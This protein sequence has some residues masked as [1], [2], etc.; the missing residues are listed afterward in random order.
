MLGR[1]LVGILDLGQKTINNIIDKVAKVPSVV[2]A[3]GKITTKI[4]DTISDYVKDRFEDS[5][6]ELVGNVTEKLREKLGSPRSLPEA[7]TRNPTGGNEAS[8]YVANDPN[9]GTGRSIVAP[10]APTRGRPAFEPS[11][12][13]LKP[14]ESAKVK[15]VRQYG[16]TGVVAGVVS[17]AAE[18]SSAESPEDIEV[19]RPAYVFLDGETGPH[20]ITVR[21]KAKSTSTSQK[22]FYYRPTTSMVPGENLLYGTLLPQTKLEQGKKF[23]LINY[24]GSVGESVLSFTAPCNGNSWNLRLN[25]R[26]LLVLYY[27]GTGNRAGARVRVDTDAYVNGRYHQAILYDF[28]GWVTWNG[29]SFK[30]SI[31]SIS[32]GSLNA[33]VEFRWDGTRYVGSYSV[34]VAA[35][36]TSPCPSSLYLN[37]Y[38]KSG[39]IMAPP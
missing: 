17:F 34:P 22:S 31:P 13:S 35:R 38:S 24:S 1:D 8:D 33:D 10:L 16:D 2:N 15:V 3:P 23:E 20:E 21:A 27:G 36:Q 6:W 9:A 25:P 18:Y 39:L 4:V 12:I 5:A 29:S 30:G 32:G 19:L 37:D 26:A 28:R 11:S 14:G 7:I